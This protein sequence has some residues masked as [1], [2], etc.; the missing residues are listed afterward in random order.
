MARLKRP[1]Q[2]LLALFMV[3]AGVMHFVRPAFY[4]ALMPP[5]L[6]APLALVYLS[7]V[8]EIAFGVALMIPRCT[9]WAAWGIVATLIAVYPANLYHAFQGGLSDPALPAA[10]ANPVTAWARLPVQ[11]VFLAWAWWYTRPVAQR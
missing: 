8:A 1:L 10:M 11:L 5:F 4:V 9:R 2:W 7:G 6:P 3:G